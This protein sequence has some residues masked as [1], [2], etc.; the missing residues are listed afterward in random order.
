MTVTRENSELIIRIPNATDLNA[1]QVQSF[2]DYLR[3][4]QVADKNKATPEQVEQFA[5]EV[6]AAWWQ[7]NKDRFTE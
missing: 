3:L 6:N 1:E 4:Q 5:R 7:E 2:L